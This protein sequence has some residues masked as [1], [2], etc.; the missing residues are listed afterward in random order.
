V[1]VELLDSIP[2]EAS[3]KRRYVISKVEPTTAT[4]DPEMIR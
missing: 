2:A 4:S 1:D 3:G